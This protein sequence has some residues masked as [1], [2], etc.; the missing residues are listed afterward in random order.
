MQIANSSKA[1]TCTQARLT[2]MITVYTSGGD[3][4]KEALL[5]SSSAHKVL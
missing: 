3:L 4:G 1:L 2:F 5:T